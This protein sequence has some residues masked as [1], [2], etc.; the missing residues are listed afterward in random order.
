MIT[1]PIPL[2]LNRLYHPGKHGQ[3][4]KSAEGKRYHGDVAMIVRTSGHDYIDKGEIVITFHVYRPRKSGDLDNYQKV[5]F[6]ALQGCAYRND[7]QIVGLHG[8][9]HEDKNNP[10]VEVFIERVAS[11]E[12][13]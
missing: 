3:L 2:S 10:R 9:R 4:Y 8:Y 5:L 11:D 12:T 1:L 7:S 6:D 13:F